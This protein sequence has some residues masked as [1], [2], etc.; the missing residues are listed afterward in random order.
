MAT[1]NDI[2][3]QLHDLPQ[4]ICLL[5]AF[6]SAGKTRLSV[7]FKDHTKE[8]N[9]GKHAGVYY[10]AFSEDLFVWDNDEENFNENVKL[11]VVRS[12]LNQFHSL[13]LDTDLLEEKLSY[14]QPM[15]KF[16]LNLYED[17]DS[18]RCQA[19]CRLFLK[20]IC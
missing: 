5:Y 14:Y 20:T 8:Q 17:G 3:Q 2:A 6:N 15:Y 10:N 4:K 7:A 9:E 18:G 1:I 16:N 19:S 13:L 11:Y 12:S